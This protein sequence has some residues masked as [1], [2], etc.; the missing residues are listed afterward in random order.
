MCL[1]RQVQLQAAMRHGP[2]GSFLQPAPPAGQGDQA[3]QQQ[4]SGSGNDAASVALLAAA[5]NARRLA[6]GGGVPPVPW[7]HPSQSSLDSAIT[8]SQ[9]SAAAAE[10][11][12]HF[13]VR[14]PVRTR[15]F[16]MHKFWQ[17][18]GDLLP[19]EDSVAFDPGRHSCRLPHSPAFA[20]QGPAPLL[21]TPCK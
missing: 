3:Q 13:K 17:V 4:H 20:V 16:C 9:L 2:L 12:E 18:C 15:C 7:P 5:R 19:C 10:R 21:E 11:A 8:R 6:I 1:A 14:L